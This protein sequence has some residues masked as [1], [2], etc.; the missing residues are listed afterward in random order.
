MQLFSEER[1]GKIS[2]ISPGMSV[3][4]SMRLWRICFVYKSLVLP[5]HHPLLRDRASRDPGY[6]LLSTFLQGALADQSTWLCGESRR[7]A[8]LPG[9]WRGGGKRSQLE[10][11]SLW[12]DLRAES[13]GLTIP[14]PAAQ[15]EMLMRM[16]IMGWCHPLPTV[17]ARNTQVGSLSSL[18]VGGRL[19]SWRSARCA[20][21]ALGSWFSGMG[22][23][24]L[25]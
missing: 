21:V 20:E 5:Q 15:P 11:Q 9:C 16:K 24:L 18:Y 25:W 8:L 10:G 13:N 4:G 17:S 22:R 1:V 23:C 12:R 3:P 2:S 6:F 14:Q 7:L 19:S